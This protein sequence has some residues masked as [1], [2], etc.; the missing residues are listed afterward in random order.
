[1]NVCMVRLGLTDCEELI[2]TLNIS[3][4]FSP[5]LYNISIKRMTVYVFCA[6]R[7]LCPS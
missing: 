4:I 1:M 7:D 3:G 6:L 5:S 2:V